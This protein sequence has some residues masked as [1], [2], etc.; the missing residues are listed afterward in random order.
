MN[1]QSLKAFQSL[2]AVQSKEDDVHQH[3][4]NKKGKM[5]S[6]KAPKVQHLVTPCIHKFQSSALKK[7]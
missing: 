2:E 3:V 5:P 4:L 6:T 7:Q 1:Y